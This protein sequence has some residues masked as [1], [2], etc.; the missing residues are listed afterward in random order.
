MDEPVTR[1][2]LIRVMHLKWVHSCFIMSSA[3]VLV[4]YFG[5]SDSPASPSDPTI[6]MYGVMWYVSLL[7]IRAFGARITLIVTEGSAR[8]RP[9]LTLAASC[10]SIDTGHTCESAVSIQV[11]I[12]HALVHQGARFH[13]PRCP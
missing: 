13:G 3:T 1:N 10:V 7:V 8:S 2:R 12:C 5:T 11:G 6:R 4:R 9:P